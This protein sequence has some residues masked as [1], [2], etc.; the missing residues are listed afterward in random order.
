MSPLPT[1]AKLTFLTS[2]IV[3]FLSPHSQSAHEN[4]CQSMKDIAMAYIVDHFDIVSKSEGIKAISH[5]LLLEILSL[6][7]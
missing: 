1:A 5:G 6:R 7:P 4:C 2:T 3:F